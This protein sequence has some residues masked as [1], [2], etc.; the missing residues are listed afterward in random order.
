LEMREAEKQSISLLQRRSA[1]VGTL[2]NEMLLSDHPL[3]RQLVAEVSLS[4]HSF[5]SFHPTKITCNNVEI[6]FISCHERLS[7]YHLTEQVLTS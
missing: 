3:S 5:L 2:E 4:I 7:H 6:I 1:A